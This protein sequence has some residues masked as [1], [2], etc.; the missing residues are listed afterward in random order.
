MG[1]ALSVCV[2]P[3][4]SGIRIRWSGIKWG[5]KVGLTHPLVDR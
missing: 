4:W 5:G 3:R 1:V 2:P